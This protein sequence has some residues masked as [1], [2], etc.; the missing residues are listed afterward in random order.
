M[1]SPVVP[2]NVKH[3]TSAGAAIFP[4]IGAWPNFTVLH[5]IGSFSRC[6]KMLKFCVMDDET[7]IVQVPVSPTPQWSGPGVAH[8]DS[9]AGSK[10]SVSGVDVPDV[11]IMLMKT[12]FTPAP[13]N[14]KHAASAV[15]DTVPL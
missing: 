1:T 11:A 9:P 14:V 4:V 2:E 12:A 7:W 3:A 15:L 10:R 8:L 5:P 13:E 6:T